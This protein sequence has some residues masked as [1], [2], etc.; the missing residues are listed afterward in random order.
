LR[1]KTHEGGTAVEDQGLLLWQAGDAVSTVNQVIASGLWKHAKPSKQ[2]LVD[3]PLAM[4]VSESESGNGLPT[5]LRGV[6]DLVFLEDNGWVIVDYKSERVDES[7]ITAMA[8]Y[9][10]PQVA[11]YAKVW[12]DISGQRVSEKC[13][14]FTHFT[15]SVPTAELGLDHII[16]L[17]R[18]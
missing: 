1:W 8:N 16:R 7:E 5:V 15:H 10:Q 17:P 2:R 14:R 12:E 9:Y 4:P 6:I 11:A 18:R 3:V 13:F